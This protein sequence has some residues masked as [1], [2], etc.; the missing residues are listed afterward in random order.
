[1]R[2][3]K[4]ISGLIAWLLA[5]VTALAGIGCIVT[6]FDLD[7]AE[8]WASIHLFCA[9]F[10]AIAAVCCSFRWGAPVMTVLSLALLVL[11]RKAVAMSAA[12]LLYRISY[13]FDAAYGWG[14][15]NPT[16][17]PEFGTM[18]VVY[19]IT[20][21]PLAP[22]LI[23]IG[24]MVI[25]AICWVVCSRRWVGFGLLAG[26]APL[27]LCC[28]V[29]DTVPEVQCLSFLIGSLMLLT[30]TQLVRKLDIRSGNRL[31]AL[32]LIPVLLLSM[33]LPQLAQAEDRHRQ[34]Q[35]LQDQLLGLLNGWSGTGIEDP[36]DVIT[37]SVDLSTVGPMFMG[38][39]VKLYV[40][41]DYEGAL[42]LRGT[43]YDTYTGT[44]WE[45]LADTAGERGW[46]YSGIDPVGTLTI[47][48]A[49]GTTQ[50][51]Y[52]P[53]YTKGQGWTQYLDHGTLKQEEAVRSYS[54]DFYTSDEALN[55]LFTPLSFEETETYLAL[56]R[57]T[58]LAAERILIEIFAEDHPSSQIM[59]AALI[60]QYVSHSASYDLQTEAMPQDA[61]DFAIWFL[62]N[63]N[64]GYCVHFAS[65]ATILLRAAGIPARYVTGYLTYATGEAFA[66]TGEQA[67]AWVEYLHPTRGWT[68]LEATPGIL[69]QIQPSEPTEPPSEETTEPSEDTSEPTEDTTEPSEE[70]TTPSEDTTVP[71]EGTTLPSPTGPHSGG[72]GEEWD[73]T[74]IWYILWVLLAWSLLALQHRLRRRLRRKWLMKGDE[75]Q[76]AL[77]RWRYV[78]RT[79]RILKLPHPEHLQ[80]LAEK[81]V[82]SQH[83]L[84]EEELEQFDLWLQKAK[85]HLLT[86]PW[87][88]RLALWFIYAI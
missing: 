48:L 73:L 57:N 75:K 79:V 60:G 30:I 23:V 68:V 81:A 25:S 32:A 78:R 53:Y 65:A 69:Q 37:E 36:S 67:H 45:A 26:L 10:A 6:G 2:R 1:M 9:M 24:C 74:W 84:T 12:V 4:I 27:M 7:I 31:T 21:I 39:G 88:I 35:Q 47:T 64:T 38:T 14:I 56:P 71:S 51:R 62:Q 59:Q 5:L 85:R 13:L 72:Q 41:V 83:T 34:A 76:R 54:F 52:F 42:Y 29:T 28:V 11:F 86:K 66:V 61:T 58:R 55:H 50:R 16:I 46:P 49:G 80:A 15:V 70:S 3:D 63:S 77:R 40:D 18:G 44:T 20:Q 17:P 82:F 8:E 22:A 33:V 87:P 43:A 19:P